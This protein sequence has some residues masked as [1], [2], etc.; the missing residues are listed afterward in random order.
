MAELRLGPIAEERGLAGG[1]YAGEPGASAGRWG[2]KKLVSFLG[3][4]V[5]YPQ[6]LTHTVLVTKAGCTQVSVPILQT[7]CG[8]ALCR[9]LPLHLPQPQRKDRYPGLLL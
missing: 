4:A 1:G 7:T 2:L 5:L 9:V 6:L 3:V 8:S